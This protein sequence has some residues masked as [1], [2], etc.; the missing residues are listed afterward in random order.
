MKMNC[1]NQKSKSGNSHTAAK[2]IIVSFGWLEN[3]SARYYFSP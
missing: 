3:G 2:N 1:G